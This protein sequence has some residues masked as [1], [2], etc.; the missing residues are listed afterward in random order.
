MLKL[1]AKILGPISKAQAQ[2]QTQSFKYI[3]L[4]HCKGFDYLQYEWKIQEFVFLNM[5]IL[6]MP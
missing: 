3:G 2:C 5:Q 4:I 6:G 1:D